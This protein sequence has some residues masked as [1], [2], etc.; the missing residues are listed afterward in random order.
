MA[1]EEAPQFETYVASTNVPAL[2]FTSTDGVTI[3]Y[4]SGGI[5][6]GCA[7]K[8][9]TATG[10]AL[11]VILAGT[12]GDKALGICGEAPA[13]TAGQNLRVCVRGVCKAQAG[14]AV[15]VGDTVMVGNASGQL[16]TATAATANFVVG[17]ALTAATAIGDLFSVEVRPSDGKVTMP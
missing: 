9:D 4:S 5:A 12:S 16:I 8:H 14:A 15:A 3:V 1:F 6:F 7:V 10:T 11:D 13:V 17:R 2:S